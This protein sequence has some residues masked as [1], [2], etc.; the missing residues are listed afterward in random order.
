MN[1]IHCPGLVRS[2]VS[3]TV[4]GRRKSY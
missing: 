3:V 4:L 2:R 1:E